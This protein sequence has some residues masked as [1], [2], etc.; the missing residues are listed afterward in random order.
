MRYIYIFIYRF[1]KPEGRAFPHLGPVIVK[2]IKKAPNS[3]LGVFAFY[4]TNSNFK[5]IKT[6]E[7]TYRRC[8]LYH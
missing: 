3:L 1:I 5:N 8:A 4:K 6:D 7:T 2:A